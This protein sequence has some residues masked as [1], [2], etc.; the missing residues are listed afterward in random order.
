MG[1]QTVEFQIEWKGRQ[2]AQIH[3]VI[4]NDKV[5]ATDGDNIVG[6][7]SLLVK[8]S[9]QEAPLHHLEWS[10]F[11]PNKSLTGLT[12]QASIDGEAFTEVGSKDDAKNRW[13]DEGTVLPGGNQ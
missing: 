7:G 10:L 2:K 3:F 13:T 1:K 5:V 4:D 9:V 8:Y 11:F 6:Q 12:A